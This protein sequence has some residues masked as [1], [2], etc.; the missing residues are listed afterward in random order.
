MNHCG[1]SEILKFL[2]KYDKAVANKTEL[3]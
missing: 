3:L 1:I 2:E